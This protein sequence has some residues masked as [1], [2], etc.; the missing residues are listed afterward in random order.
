MK[1]RRRDKMLS[2]RFT[3]K[4]KLFIDYIFN[5]YD[6]SSTDTFLE[7]MRYYYVNVIDKEN[8]IDKENYIN[9]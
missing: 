2:L 5:K 4:E 9:E 7:V 6:R 3:E 8:L 1:K